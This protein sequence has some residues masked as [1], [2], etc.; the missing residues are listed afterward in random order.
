M[1]PDSQSGGQYRQRPLNGESFRRFAVLF[2]SGCGTRQPPT[3]QFRGVAAPFQVAG[4]PAPVRPVGR[5]DSAKA[6]AACGVQALTPVL[7]IGQRLLDDIPPSARPGPAHGEADGDH[8]RAPGDR[9]PSSRHSGRRSERHPLPGDR[10]P[11]PPVRA[12]RP[13]GPDV[14]P[15]RAVHIRGGPTGAGRGRE[16]WPQ[17]AARSGSRASLAWVFPLSSSSRRVWSSCW[18]SLGRSFRYWRTFSLP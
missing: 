7:P 16:S 10:A 1:G 5:W 15:F 4:L 2:R 12:W 11:H 3:D 18:V 17:S 14:R 9:A 6:A 8:H 13:S